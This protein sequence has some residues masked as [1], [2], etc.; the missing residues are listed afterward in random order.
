MPFTVVGAPWVDADRL[1]KALRAE[2][3]KGVDFLPVHFKPTSSKF[4]KQMC[5]GVR[6]V[7][8]DRVNFDPV[9]LGIALAVALQQQGGEKFEASKMST[10]LAQPTVLK[11]IAQGKSRSEIEGLWK[12]DN[13]AFLDRRKRF[14]RYP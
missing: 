4:A 14:L 12:A 6:L 10:L 5:H 8:F 1:Q 13:S 7:L 3:L 2:Q 9:S 11:A